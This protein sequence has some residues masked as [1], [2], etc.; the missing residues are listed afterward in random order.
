MSRF[1]F[2]VVLNTLPP[3]PTMLAAD[4]FSSTSLT[5]MM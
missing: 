3:F 1:R 4:Y 5:E 2:G